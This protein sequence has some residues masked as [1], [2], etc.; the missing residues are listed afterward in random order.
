MKQLRIVTS[1]ALI[2]IFSS[3]FSQD[4]DKILKD[5][6]KASGQDKIVKLKS[7]VMT[8]KTI[9]PSMGMEMPFVITIARPNKIRIES[10]FQGTKVIQT[11]NGEKGWMLAPMMGSNEPTELSGTELNLL[12]TQGD[13]DGPLWNYEEKGNKVELV[14]EEDVNGSPAYHLKITT[15]DGDVMHQYIDKGSY[16]ITKAT[17]KQVIGGA[18]TEVENIMGDYKKIDGIAI[19]HSIDSK[20]NGQSITKVVVESVNFNKDIDPAI[21]EK[22]S[23]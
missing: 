22:P 3:A 13:F 14:G 4:V 10:N 6:F 15:K 21:F 1:I 12:K 16:L 17:T 11:Y 20:M 23:I 18:E 19:P 5:H 9:I 7:Q 2:A 8:G